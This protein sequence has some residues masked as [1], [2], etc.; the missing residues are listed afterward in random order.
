MLVYSSII[1]DGRS[2]GQQKS[3]GKKV[4]SRLKDFLRKKRNDDN[5]GHNE[6]G[7]HNEKKKKKKVRTAENGSS[8][9]CHST[10]LQNNIGILTFDGLKSFCSLFFSSSS[11]PSSSSSSSS[12]LLYNRIMRENL[13]Q[14]VT[15]A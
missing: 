9:L 8:R 7:P 3:F 10:P 14:H 6:G 2:S 1:D 4:K 12:L 15:N 5:D 11:W 13:S